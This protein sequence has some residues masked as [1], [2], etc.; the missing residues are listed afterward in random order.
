[1]SAMNSI[2][3][4]KQTRISA[5]Y[6]KFKMILSLIITTTINKSPNIESKK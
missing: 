1:M 4:K 2:L 6:D 5:V 3:K